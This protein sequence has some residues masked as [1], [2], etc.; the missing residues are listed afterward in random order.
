MLS[1]TFTFSLFFLSPN[2]L[3]CR[4]CVFLDFVD[5]ESCC[6]YFL[7]LS[8]STEVFDCETHPCCRLDV[9]TASHCFR[10]HGQEAQGVT[11]DTGPQALASPHARVIPGGAPGA[12]PIYTP[13]STVQA[14]GSFSPSWPTLD[15]VRPFTSHQSLGVKRCLLW[16]NFA[17][18]DYTWG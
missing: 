11:L 1:F 9:W 10:A 14:S 7:Q 6:T 17:F 5:A 3:L 8:S 13:A 15:F 18:A 16:L 4:F 2:N 12:R